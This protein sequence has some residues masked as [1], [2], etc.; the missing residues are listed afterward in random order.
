M[1]RLAQETSPYLLQHANNPVDWFPWGEEA[2]QKARIE[3][4]PI[5]VSIGYSACHWCH[6]MEKESFEHE[7]VAEIMNANFVNIKIDREERPDL[8]HIYMDAVQ[9]MSGG[10]GWPLNVFLTPDCK[11]FYGGTYFP[12]VRAHNR[13]SW[14]EILHGIH[15]SFQSNRAE[16]EEQAQ[17]L[18]DHLQQANAFGLQKKLDTRE[19]NYP[20]TEA[21]LQDQFRN[22][23][24]QADTLW[25]G[26]G[27]APKFPQTFTIQW[28]LQYHHFTGEKTALQQACTSLDKM[29]M[30]GL[31]DHVAGGFARYSTD[32]QWLVPHFEK[33]LYDNALLVITLAEAYQITKSPV[34]EET[35]RKTL[36]FIAAEMMDENGAFFSALDADSEGEEGKYYVWT[37][38]KVK[39]ILGE[40]ADWFCNLYDITPEGNWEDANILRLKLWPEDEN[41]LYT[42]EKINQ[43]LE[44]L[45]RVRANRIKPLL[46]DKVILGWN[47]LMNQAF[48]KA[49]SVLNDDAYLTI[50]IKNMECI[51]ITMLSNADGAKHTFKNG[52]AKFDAFLDDYANLIKALLDLQEITGDSTYLYDAR[53]YTDFVIQH[54]SDEENVYFYYTHEQQHD[55]IVR[56]KEIYDG[57]VPSGNAVM[58]KNLWNLSKFFEEPSWGKRVENM[59]NGVLKVAI[60]YPTSFGYWS[61]LLFNLVYGTWEIVAD[62]EQHQAFAKLLLQEYIPNKVFQQVLS[63]DNQ[64]PMLIGKKASDISM[65][66][67]CKNN[68]CGKPV[69]SVVELL[70]V[71]NK[72]K[73]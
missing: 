33:M 58:A 56:K 19:D 60:S 21:Q 2:L 52:V 6:V 29:I 18:T 69:F 40:D 43:C 10:G 45:K 72:K 42:K 67:Y 8:D 15:Q 55:V 71:I 73:C 24:Q 4:K 59:V 70:E 35:I 32:R 68:A 12:P 41:K 61:S 57:A 11:P 54:F 16:I 66:H 30:G 65:L 49:A 34:Y 36:G 62:G 25:G 64:F 9:A 20:F 51:K 38:E 27:N 63:I 13:A 7:A 5:L 28:L 53:K 46:D 14:K 22:I 39:T 47:A 48:T 31:Y 44:Q 23:I 50:A 26:F 3:D 37:Y 17:Q 1:N